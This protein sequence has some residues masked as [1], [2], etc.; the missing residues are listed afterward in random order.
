MKAL[1]SLLAGTALASTLIAAAALA[2]ETA[3][4]TVTP[5]ADTVVA[6][7]NGVD[8]TLGQMIVMKARLPEQYQQ[9]PAQMLFE[10]ILD[11]L[12]QQVALAS[13]Y[14]GELSKG[15]RIALENERLSYTA[16]EAINAL[17]ADLVTDEAVQAAYDEQY[18]NAEPAKEWN[19]AH[20]LLETQEDAAAVK[21]EID[22][23]ADFAETARTRSTGPS[24]PNG[25]DLGWFDEGMMV[26][27]FETA[28]KA[29]EA[30]QVSDPVQTQFGWHV[31]KLNEVRDV[32]PPTLD[33]V[34]AEIE[35]TLRRAAA[36]G[37][38]S[39]AVEAAEVVKT[40]EGLDP[41]AIDA[42]DLVID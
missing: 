13:Q 26:P 8:I 5:T 20:I 12:I 38:V 24:G 10:P 1:K 32:V 33:E 37:V 9:M 7:V 18:A 34:R 2:Q 40:T 23:G 39:G 17:T 6:T 4:A 14:T 21:A 15:A 11:Q 31:I 36:E 30:G 16:S 3:P 29:L 42:F 19:A 41:A 22:G 27:E 25:G 35:G 28:V